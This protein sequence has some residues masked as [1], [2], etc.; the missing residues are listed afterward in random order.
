MTRMAHTD[1]KILSAMA[2]WKAMNN[3]TQ[4]APFTAI[5]STGEKRESV[6]NNSYTVTI[7]KGL[8]ELHS[9]DRKIRFLAKIGPADH[10]TAQLRR[11]YSQLM[12][13]NRNPQYPEWSQFFFEELGGNA[14]ATVEQFCESQDKFEATLT[15]ESDSEEGRLWVSISERELAKVVESLC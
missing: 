14:V 15:V 9:E 7:Q 1:S 4:S 10:F 3:I 12:D 11:L 6:A 8:F 2:E 13:A 5:V